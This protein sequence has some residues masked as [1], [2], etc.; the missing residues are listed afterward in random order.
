M[1][2]LKFF[3]TAIIVA[4]IPLMANAQLK[5]MQY[6]RPYDQRGVNVFEVTKTDTVG[7]ENIDVRIGGAFTQQIQALDHSNK[8]DANVVDGVDLNE[9]KAI[10][11]GFN[12]ATA[13]LNIDVQLADGVRMNVITYLSSRHHPEA[14]VKGGYLQVDKVP[15]LKSQLLDN[16]FEYVR[17]KAG[18]MEINYGDAHF[19]RTDN[20]NAMYNPLVGNYILDAFNTEIGAEVYFFKDNFLAMIATSGGEI[21]GNITNPDG[22]APAYYGKIGYDNQFSEDL[23][24][25]LT[26]SFYTTSKSLNNSLYAGD[27]AGSRYYLVMEN[28]N[29]T[30]AAQFTSGRFNPNFRDDV[31]SFQINPFI[32]AGGLEFFGIAEWSN[33]SLATETDNRDWS[34]YG[35]EL[36]YRFLPQD[37]LYL[38]AR[39]N[40]VSGPQA[41]STDDITIKRVQLGGGWFITKNILMKA[42]YVNQTYTDFPSSSIFHEGQFDGLMLEATVAF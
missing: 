42:E 17:I 22:R 40:T 11:A 36:V 2:T 5:N 35:A 20:A 10:G 6:W 23:R 26:G 30:D 33:G 27:R 1:K 31:T 12:N 19:R 25:R 29:A 21:R 4:G 15:F 13:N 28:V 14:W 8:A 9:L 32:K 16:I 37:K 41:F 38:A 39:Y 34:Q 18:H 24:F 7:F 3:F